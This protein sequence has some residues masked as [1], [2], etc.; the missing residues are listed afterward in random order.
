MMA[1]TGTEM[2]DLM[3]QLASL[4]LTSA[5]SRAGSGAILREIE[6]K[7]PGSIVRMQ[8]ELAL[9]RAEASLLADGQPDA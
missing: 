6:A 3:M 1:S 8:A 7:T 4:D 2:A 5:D 9:P